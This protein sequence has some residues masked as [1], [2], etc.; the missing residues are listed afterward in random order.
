MPASI[1]L[2]S[3]YTR[4]TKT[5]D[6][7]DLGIYPASD[8]RFTDGATNRRN[9]Q[10]IFDEA[11]NLSGEPI[12]PAVCFP[13]GDIQLDYSAFLAPDSSTNRRLNIRGEGAFTSRL[14]AN[15]PTLMLGVSRVCPASTDGVLVDGSAS[16]FYDGSVSGRYGLDMSKYIVQDYASAFYTN[17]VTPFS[18]LTEWTLDF[19]FDLRGNANLQGLCGWS[20]NSYDG[21][22]WFSP[23]GLISQCDGTTLK[24][25][26]LLD[27]GSG[28]L[29]DANYTHYAFEYPDITGSF[30]VRG[31]IQFN[32]AGQNGNSG[33]PVIA[34]YLNGQQVNYTL[35]QWGGANS[36]P[37]IGCQLFNSRIAPFQ[38]GLVGSSMQTS[39]LKGICY[40]LRF[41]QA[42]RYN[43]GA[44]GSAQTLKSGATFND[45]SQFFALSST[46]IYL[47]LTDTNTDIADRP[48]LTCVTPSGNE[49]VWI[50]PA[51]GSELTGSS[52]VVNLTLSDLGFLGNGSGGN[53]GLGILANGLSN[54]RLEN[55]GF[56]LLAQSVATL[57]V[58][59][60]SFEN[61]YV[62]LN[63][64]GKFSHFTFR[65]A[66]LQKITRPLSGS[67]NPM[68]CILGDNLSNAEVDTFTPGM[69][70]NTV[71]YLYSGGG[72]WRLR[73]FVVDNEA[74]RNS[75][76]GG[77]EFYFN[78]QAT[79][80]RST[81]IL[82][83]FSTAFGSFRKPPVVLDGP[84]EITGTSGDKTAR[85]ECRQ[86]PS[87]ADENGQPAQI[88]V[89]SPTWYGPEVVQSSYT[90]RV[91][92]LLDGTTNG[93]SRV[94]LSVEAFDGPPRAGGYT[95]GAR[96]RS[97]SAV[98]GR[99]LEWRNTE[100]GND[101]AACY[102]T[103]KP[104]IWVATRTLDDDPSRL[105]CDLVGHWYWSRTTE[106]ANRYKQGFWSDY[107]QCQFLDWLF[108]QVAP[109][110]PAIP[111]TTGILAALSYRCGWRDQFNFEQTAGGYA[112]QTVT[113]SFPAQG[114][115]TLDGATFSAAADWSTLGSDI[116][117][118]LIFLHPTAV[119]TG[120][121]TPY[122]L[123]SLDIDPAEVL[124]GGSLTFNA[125]E[126]LGQQQPPIAGSGFA[127]AVED[128]L[129]KAWLGGGTL[130]TYDLYLALS[131]AEADIA[132]S[133][134]EP[135]G[136]GYARVHAPT[137]AWEAAT[138]G[139][140]ASR[141][142]PGD[143]S[144]GGRLLSNGVIRN[145]SALNFA[146]PTADWPE[147]KSVYLMSAL[148]GGSN[149]ACA[150]LTIPRTALNGSSALGFNAGAF[151]IAR[152]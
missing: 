126:V 130:T 86:D 25:A 136:G 33:N 73:N 81:V 89:N 109:S 64:C 29:F 56:D 152:S 65:G 93:D 91:P 83:G 11:N 42:E 19:A 8:R 41:D 121:S 15:A 123:V 102:G 124:S 116:P 43:Y 26:V 78:S 61:H 94:P 13:S 5:T 48:F 7:R 90:Q 111:G 44:S 98:S 62:D 88:L 151:R 107:V 20:L 12:F 60:N 72:G 133:P 85:F 125:A 141:S 40:G 9:L 115:V 37:P 63:L 77:C 28:D 138:Y 58:G 6:V 95:R 18:D 103:S 80:G 31:S 3:K 38:V 82:D 16:G 106:T 59:G 36:N 131:T 79:D 30:Q 74:Y 147:V 57:G 127:P 104:P 87:I 70:G 47:P 50:T 110:I 35:G 114:Q 17:H 2:P 142:M 53:L 97:T 39:A 21:F 14:S 113:F 51:G 105:A 75:L 140:G 32:S 52:S 112:R 101:G 146:A 120:T 148:T 1:A 69:S 34:L 54:C 143:N 46:A 27:I 66:G 100:A 135:S 117:Y 84:G 49:G 71:N 128:M 118:S 92:I 139:S 129:A 23:V 145:S 137:T 96:L 4:G 132:A 99:A 119:L 149:V 68:Y 76:I 108:G 24:L 22:R 55:L 10:A 45:N 67:T 144:K 122:V 150:P 134:T